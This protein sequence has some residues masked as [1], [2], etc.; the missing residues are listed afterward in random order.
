MPFDATGKWI[1]EDD[2][3]A[4]RL[5]GLLDSNSSYIKTAR[6][7]GQRTAQK[8]GLLN[9]SIAAGAGESAAIGAAAP[10]ASQD[11]Q[12]LA[13]KN[14]AVL[15]GGINFDNSSKL[16]DQQFGNQTK[17]NTQQNDAQIVLQ[18]AQDDAALQRQQ[19]QQQGAD[20]QQLAE[21]DQRTK[22]QIANLQSQADLQASQLSSQE[23]TAL[24][25]S[26][27]G[28]RETQIQANSA[29]SGQYLDAF[30][31]L[32]NNPKVPA[33][34]RNAYIAEYQRVLE[35]GRA[36]AGV[37]QSVPLDWGTGPT[38]AAPTAQPATQSLPTQQP[39][40]P[41][42][43]ASVAPAPAPAPTPNSAVVPVSTLT[44]QPASVPAPAPAPAPTAPIYSGL[45][46]PRNATYTRLVG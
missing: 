11:A 39:A 17:L 14:Q 30:A 25:S 2:S 16:A 19:L 38:T 32:A 4:T 13:Q 6:A 21:F 18:K 12:Q 33:D 10:I 31:N 45:L 46:D 20:A 36:L 7:A 44:S 15:E 9:S 40:A 5:T 41:V 42:P 22:E 27:T 28:L 23:R 29:L 3:V 35:Q 26:D 1:P 37:A 43:A 24:L 34:A 8:R